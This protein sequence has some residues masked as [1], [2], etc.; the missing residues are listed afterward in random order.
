MSGKQIDAVP[1]LKLRERDIDM[2]RALFDNYGHTHCG[3]Y[4]QVG[5]GGRVGLGDAA[6]TPQAV[7]AT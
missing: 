7:E 3:I 2:L 5:S 4:I 1:D 6:T